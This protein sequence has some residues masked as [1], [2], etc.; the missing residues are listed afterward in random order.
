MILTTFLISCFN[1]NYKHFAIMINRN[2]KYSLLFH[3]SIIRLKLLQDF[4]WLPD[5]PLA[6]WPVQLN[7]IRHD[8]F[9]GNTISL[10]LKQSFSFHR[11]S[12]TM[13]NFKIQGGDTP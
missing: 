8:N 3:S 4:Y 9:I 5:D 10:Y 7:H 2:P 11:T 6:C 13:E 1:L 12:H